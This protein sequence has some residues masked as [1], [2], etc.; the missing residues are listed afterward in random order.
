LVVYVAIDNIPRDYQVTYVRRAYLNAVPHDA[1]GPRT[2]KILTWG[3]KNAAVCEMFQRDLRLGPGVEIAVSEP[4]APRR[5]IVRF[6]A[7]DQAL[8]TFRRY[9]GVKEAPR[10][11]DRK[12]RKAK[13]RSG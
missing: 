6:E 2:V 10:Y 8:K 7:G 3:Y 12:R 13:P 11:D 1:K 5:N 4:H 9:L